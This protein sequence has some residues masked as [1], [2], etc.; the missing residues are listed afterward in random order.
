MSQPTLNLI[1]NSP[2][3]L[4]KPSPVKKPALSRAVWRK[5]QFRFPALPPVDLSY[6]IE[7]DCLKLITRLWRALAAATTMQQPLL[8][9][10]RQGQAPPS[11]TVPP[12]PT[13]HVTGAAS[14]T[15]AAAA[16][17]PAA[18]AAARRPPPGRGGV[19]ASAATMR[20][21][22]SLSPSGIASLR[23]ISI[24]VSQELKESELQLRNVKVRSFLVA[25]RRHVPPLATQG[26]PQAVPRLL[27][28]ACP[29]VRRCRAPPPAGGVLRQPPPHGCRRLRPK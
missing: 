2:C 3:A 20:P 19:A 16:T 18:A 5:C 1:I 15:P 4:S 27:P 22:P 13:R 28:A 21:L 9:N 8:S 7:I 11:R 17:G 23:D 26:R 29:R 10:L 25:W 6:F 12:S 24:D 14:T